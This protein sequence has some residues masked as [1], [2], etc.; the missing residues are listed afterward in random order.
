[1]RKD[2]RCRRRLRPSHPAPNVRDDHDTPLW[3]RDGERYAGD[4][5]EKK[6][7]IFLRRSWTGESPDSPSSQISWPCRAGARAH[8]WPTECLATVI[9]EQS[10][11]RHIF[12]QFMAWNACRCCGAPIKKYGLLRLEAPSSPQHLTSAFGN[13]GPPKWDRL[14]QVRK[15]PNSVKRRAQESRSTSTRS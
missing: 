4:L 12:G 3:V 2:R 7:R 5:G 9:G 13:T 6:T 11:N 8:S 10:P 1:M 14:L 15:A